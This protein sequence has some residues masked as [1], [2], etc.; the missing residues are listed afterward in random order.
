MEKRKAE[1]SEAIN[2]F[3]VVIDYK[4]WGMDPHKYKEQYSDR[5][6]QLNV[7]RAY[8]LYKLMKEENAPDD[9][10]LAVWTY[11]MVCIDARKHL[12][13][14]DK[15]AEQLEFKKLETKYGRIFV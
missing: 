1:I 10:L 5:K 8:K 9:E 3:N 13:D 2:D 14:M 7:G 4:E 11:M 15:A 12:L 6:Q